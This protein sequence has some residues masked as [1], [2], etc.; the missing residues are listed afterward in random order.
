MDVIIMKSS[1]KKK[2]PSIHWFSCEPPYLYCSSLIIIVQSAIACWYDELQCSTNGYEVGSIS[3]QN[4]E[5][6]TAFGQEKVFKWSE[7]IVMWQK[8]LQSICHVKTCTIFLINCLIVWRYFGS[9]RY[10][11]HVCV[12]SLSFSLISRFPYSLSLLSTSKNYRIR[13]WVYKL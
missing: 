10:S 2:H 5:D 8:K 13:L 6:Q 1:M 9:R 3:F 11:G 4:G 12:L 7:P